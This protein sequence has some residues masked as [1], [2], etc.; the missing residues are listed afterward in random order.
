MLILYHHNLSVCAQKVR[1]ALAE[2]GLDWEDRPVDLM[3]GEH[4]R[5]DYL[6]LNPKGVVPTLVH[7]GQPVIESTLILEYLEDA[8]PEHPFRP[9]APIERARMRVW[10]KWPDDGLHAACGTVSYAAAFREQLIA[11]HGAEALEARI[12]K[13]P[14]RSR[15]ARQKELYEKGMEAS[16]LPDHLRLQDKVLGEMESRLSGHDWLAGDDYSDAECAL[17]PY[18]WRLERLGLEGMWES[19]PNVDAWFAT[20]KGRPSWG[21]AMVAYKALG[22]HDYD[23][24]LKSRGVDLWP[25]FKAMLAA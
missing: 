10:T 3:K 6:T 18:L 14:D 4:L 15:A 17:L 8:F 12:A 2:K 20:C 13:L 22:D 24:D 5:A 23:D 25:Q 16:F 7:D 1:L 11:F 19:R 21:R 9:E